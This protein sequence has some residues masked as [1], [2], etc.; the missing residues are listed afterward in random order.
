MLLYEKTRIFYYTHTNCQAP[1]LLQLQVATGELALFLST[2]SRIKAVHQVIPSHASPNLLLFDPRSWGQYGPCWFRFCV[3]ILVQLNSCSEIMQSASINWH[4]T[5]DF[6]INQIYAAK[7]MNPGLTTSPY[8]WWT[9]VPNLFHDKNSLCLVVSCSISPRIYW[10][11][12]KKVL[13]QLRGNTFLIE[14][15]CCGG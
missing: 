7:R 9:S 15:Y 10:S 2:R 5:L 11:E 6:Q 13:V 12:K 1:T 4:G 3:T 14:P 8:H